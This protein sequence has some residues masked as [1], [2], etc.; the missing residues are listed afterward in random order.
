MS[1]GL[2]APLRNASCPANTNPA[3][4]ESNF[5]RLSGVVCGIVG[6]LMNET[7]VDSAAGASIEYAAIAAADKKTNPVR[8]AAMAARC[9]YASWLMV[10]PKRSR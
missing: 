1:L 5:T 3:G 4:W 10:C 2:T 9:M 6:R 8:H 7:G